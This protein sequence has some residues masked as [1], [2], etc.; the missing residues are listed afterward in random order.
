MWMSTA[1]FRA[2][3]CAISL[4]RQEFVD[5][6]KYE[7][8]TLE[9]SFD[10][11][12]HIEV[13]ISYPQLPGASPLMHYVNETVKRDAHALYDTYIQK[14]RAPQRDVGEEEELNERT[15]YY[16]LQ[17]VY[18]SS[19]L[20][21]LYGVE[22]Q[23]AGGVHGSMHYMTRTFWQNGNLVR[24]LSL[25]DL[26]LSEECREQ[27]FRY[28]ENYFKSNQCGYYSYDDYSWVGFGPEHLD[29]FLLT[30]QGLLLLFQNY[31]VSGFNDFPTTL[32]VSYALLAFMANSDGPLPALMK[33]DDR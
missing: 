15:L 31:I 2:L 19:G 7:Q 10:T 6:V 28:C 20:I 24:E 9:N 33:A 5:D 14:M 3:A 30:Q 16:R 27:L 11:N 23:Y 13:S 17:S 1:F 25:D 29:A 22:Y 4:G 26:F 18:C 32:L 12:V 21:S 8:Q